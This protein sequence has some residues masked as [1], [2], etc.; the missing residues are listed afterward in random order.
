L[1][2]QL[3]SSGLD[4]KGA[5]RERLRNRHRAPLAIALG[6]EQRNA[7]SQCFQIIRIK[8][9]FHATILSEPTEN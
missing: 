7:S 8:Q 1:R 2:A 5:V 4:T 9:V 6:P 3:A